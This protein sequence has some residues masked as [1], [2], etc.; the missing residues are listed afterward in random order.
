MHQFETPHIFHKQEQ[1]YGATGTDDCS[2][3]CP[4]TLH[5]TVF[6]E[7]EAAGSNPVTPTYR[8]PFY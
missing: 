5:E 4:K 6:W 2:G 8:Q 1:E 3:N 7:Q